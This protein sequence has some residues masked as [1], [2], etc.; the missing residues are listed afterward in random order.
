M[1]S[2]SMY[3]RGSL[4]WLKIKVVH[5]MLHLHNAGTSLRILSSKSF[6][7]E[8]T[9]FLRDYAGATILSEHVPRM[10]NLTVS[11]NKCNIQI[12]RTNI[13]HS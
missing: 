7:F 11:S 10:T 6:C 2:L 1:H 9:G 8:S 13:V 3:S 4:D 5:M 12:Q